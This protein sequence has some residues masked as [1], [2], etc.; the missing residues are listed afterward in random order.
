MSKFLSICESHDP[1]NSSDPKWELVDFLKSKG[2]NA[3][4]VRNTDMVYI[5]T[6]SRTIAVTIS[7]MEEDEINM[8]G[9]YSVDDEVEK[10]GNKA[11]SGLK[12]MAARAL[13]TNPQKAKSAMKKRQKLVGKAINVYNKKTQDLEKNLNNASRSSV[14]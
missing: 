3:S 12:G 11:N 5:D 2:I 4:I 8:G 10:V 13:G 14:V 1:S 7:E 6:G 9:N